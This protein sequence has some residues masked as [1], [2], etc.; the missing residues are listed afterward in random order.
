MAIREVLYLAVMTFITAAKIHRVTSLSLRT[1]VTHP[2]PV[3]VCVCVYLWKRIAINRM[4]N[5]MGFTH[6]FARPGQIDSKANADSLLI[7]PHFAHANS[8]L[9]SSTVST[10]LTVD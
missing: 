5:S 8:E 2:T 4:H 10:L 1:K 7:S 9:S 3:S 6:V